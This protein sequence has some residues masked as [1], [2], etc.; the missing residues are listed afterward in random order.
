MTI[1]AEILAG[2]AIVVTAG[3]LFVRRFARELAEAT[4][5]A[6]RHGCSGCD[7]CGADKSE[8]RRV[9]FTGVGK[10]K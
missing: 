9:T 6:E 4:S 10:T 8:T 2:V 3:A 5:E 7:G 1:D